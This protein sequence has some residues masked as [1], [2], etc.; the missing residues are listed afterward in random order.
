MSENWGDTSPVMKDKQGNLVAI[1]VIF[2]NFF[3]SNFGLQASEKQVSPSVIDV[4]ADTEEAC[5][6]SQG[7]AIRPSAKSGNP[8]EK[9]RM[10]FVCDKCFTGT[11]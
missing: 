3:L 5:S 6:S 9:R 2:G 1:K 11:N 7:L 4:T 8:Q 10:G